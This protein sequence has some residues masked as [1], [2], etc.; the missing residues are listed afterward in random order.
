MANKEDIKR[1]LKDRTCD[2]CLRHV[3]QSF[4][5]HCNYDGN[6]HAIPEIRTCKLWTD[7]EKDLWRKYDNGREVKLTTTEWNKMQAR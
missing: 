7:Q 6:H 1:L 3:S 4:V 5:R 2:N